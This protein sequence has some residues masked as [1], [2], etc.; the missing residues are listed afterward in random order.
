MSLPHKSLCPKESDN[1]A[2]LANHGRIEAYDLI[3]AYICLAGV[4]C[5]LPPSRPS[6][7]RSELG[8]QEGA[9]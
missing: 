6:D 4:L 7:D 5:C 9:P 2:V 8:P 1:L 3:D